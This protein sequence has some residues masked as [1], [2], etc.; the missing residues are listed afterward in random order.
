MRFRE[1]TKFIVHKTNVPVLVLFMHCSWD[2]Q[3]LYSEKNIKN[4]SHG[5]IH[6]FK[7]YFTAVFSE[8]WTLTPKHM[9]FHLLRELDPN[10]KAYGFS[11]TSLF[12]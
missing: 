1:E 3:P 10:T 6:T 11:P 9:A 4:E 5:T 7:N 2:P 12:F 8:N